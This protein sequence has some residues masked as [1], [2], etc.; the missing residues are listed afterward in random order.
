VRRH[1]LLVI[2]CV[3][4]IPP[5]GPGLHSRS[6]VSF[7]P[8]GV[9]GFIEARRKTAAGRAAGLGSSSRG[10]PRSRSAWPPLICLDVTLEMKVAEAMNT[11]IGGKFEQSCKKPP[12]GL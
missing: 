10:S 1:P 5:L 9:P 11:A 3:N 12:A 4:F 8:F 6:A 7:A 2:I